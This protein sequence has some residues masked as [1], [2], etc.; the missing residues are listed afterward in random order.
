MKYNRYLRHLLA[1]L[2]IGI[3]RFGLAPKALAQSDDSNLLKPAEKPE[4][5]HHYNHRAKPK[6]RKKRK[7]N[8]KIKVDNKTP[9]EQENVSDQ[10]IV[11]D[12]AD[13]KDS[14]KGR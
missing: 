1:I 3:L 13:S 9:Q 7:Q 6:K 10:N 11:S 8:F 4:V 14:K 2:A 12:Q 5:T